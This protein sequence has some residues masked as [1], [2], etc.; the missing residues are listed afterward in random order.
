MFEV[1]PAGTVINRFKDFTVPRLK[2][3]KKC[4]TFVGTM[5]FSTQY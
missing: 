3:T 2:N 1:Y 4:F 5:C